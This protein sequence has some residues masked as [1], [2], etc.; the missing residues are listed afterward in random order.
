MYRIVKQYALPT[1]VQ[2]SHT[3]QPPSEWDR[4]MDRKERWT[5]HSTNLCPPTK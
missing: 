2:C 4:Q 5:N 1:A 3:V